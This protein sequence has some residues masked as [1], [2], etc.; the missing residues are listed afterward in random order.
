MASPTLTV[1]SRIAA[2]AAEIG[3]STSLAR[4]IST[5]TGAVKAPS[6]SLAPARTSAG[7]WPL[8]SACPN[9]KLRDCGRR[10]GQHQVAEAREPGQRLRPRAERPAEAREFGKSA[11]DQRRGGAGAERRGRRRCRRRS[12]ARSWRRRRSRRRARRSNGRAGRWPSRAPARARRRCFHRAP[13]ASPRSAGRVRRRRR[14]S[15]LTGSPA[16]PWA[17]MRQRCR[18]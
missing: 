4:A 14:S 11:R 6:D 7:V 8:P 3:I 1:P 13:R 15:V 18:T 5:S 9:E 2:T 12:P 10:A 17:R 16:P